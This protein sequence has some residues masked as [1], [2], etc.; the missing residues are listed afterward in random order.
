[1]ISGHVVIF[2]AI[3]GQIARIVETRLDDTDPATGR[4]QAN[5][6]GNATGMDAAAITG[7]ANYLDPNRYDMAF[8]L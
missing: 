1:L 8:R 3:E 5:E 7:A 4:I 6:V 2:G